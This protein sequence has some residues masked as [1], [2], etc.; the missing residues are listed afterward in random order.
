MSTDIWIAVFEGMPAAPTIP[1]PEAEV[2]VLDIENF[3]GWVRVTATEVP[4][5]TE[6]TQREIGYQVAKTLRSHQREDQGRW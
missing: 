6:M 4:Q 2:E 3:A 1:H 5:L